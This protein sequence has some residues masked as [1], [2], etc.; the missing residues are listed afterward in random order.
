[1]IFVKCHIIIIYL[2][3]DDI[4]YIKYNLKLFLACNE[5]I[6]LR[7]CQEAI[8]YASKNRNNAE[9]QSKLRESFCGTEFVNGIKAPK[10][11][12]FFNVFANT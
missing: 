2:D 3:N 5:C 7:S 10:V 12:N 11:R 4:C 6:L 8:E 1:M 9:S